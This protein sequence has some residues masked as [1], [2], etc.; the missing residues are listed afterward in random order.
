[1]ATDPSTPGPA[2]TPAQDSG[3]EPARGPAPGSAPRS[4]LGSAPGHAPKP[5]P[6]SRAT[7]PADAPVNPSAD[8]LANPEAPEAHA[9][10]PSAAASAD[11]LFPRIERVG[12]VFHRGEIDEEAEDRAYWRKASQSERLRAGLLLRRMAYGDS[13]TEGLQR[14]YRVA[15]RT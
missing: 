10:P 5:A 9:P 8:S 14:V 6:A 11:E 15:K 4:A 7:D 12:R 3:L 13:A 2:P 1:M